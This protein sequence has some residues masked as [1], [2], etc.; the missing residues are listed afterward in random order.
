MSESSSRG[1]RRCDGRDTVALVNTNFVSDSGKRDEG[2]SPQTSLA[3]FPYSLFG[4]ILL[5]STHEVPEVGERQVRAERNRA[6]ALALEET[7][8]MKA[9][10]P[11]IIDK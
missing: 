3:A 10:G 5:V 6:R 2:R 7:T 8:Y 11:F 9:L 1:A 4:P